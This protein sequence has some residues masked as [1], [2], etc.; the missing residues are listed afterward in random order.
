MP[1]PNRLSSPSATQVCSSSRASVTWL[2]FLTKSMHPLTT[3][4]FN[5]APKLTSPLNC[6]RHT[7]ALIKDSWT[8]SSAS[9]GFFR[10]RMATPNMPS[11][12]FRYR[13]ICAC[14]SWAR[15]FSTSAIW[16][17]FGSM[18]GL[19]AVSIVMAQGKGPCCRKVGPSWEFNKKNPGTQ[20]PRDVFLWGSI[21]LLVQHQVEMDRD[22][23]PGGLAVRADFVGRVYEFLPFLFVQGRQVRIQGGLQEK[24]LLFLVQGYVGRDTEIPQIVH[25]LLLGH[26]LQGGGKTAGICRGEKLFGIGRFRVGF[27][28]GIGHGYI[29]VQ[30]PVPGPYMS[31]PSPRIGG[32]AFKSCLHV[33][34]F[35][36]FRYGHPPWDKPIFTC[37]R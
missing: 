28:L 27:P 20:G 22:V 9:S 4:R 17:S 33:S 3:I 31:G 26:R 14:L 37:K 2:F 19:L 25:P 24:T 36:E 6:S 1:S 21:G 35:L 12:Y 23:V 15:H 34:R 11:Q 29:K 16:D 18:F 8:T 32:L 30:Y 13:S 5:Q 7:K 10:K